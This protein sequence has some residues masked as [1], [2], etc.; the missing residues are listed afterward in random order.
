M[1]PLTKDDLTALMD[2]K[3]PWSDVKDIVSR[4]RHLQISETV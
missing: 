3:L 1:M 4:P 2:G